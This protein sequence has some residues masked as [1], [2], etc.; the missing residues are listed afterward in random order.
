MTPI[1][2]LLL[3][4]L[5]AVALL[6]AAGGTAPAH[7]QGDTTAVALNTKDGS[8]LFKFAFQVRRTMRDVVDSTNAA[9]AVS[10]CSDCR[11]VAVSF[12]VLLVGGDASTQTPTNLALAI[13]QNCSSC[14]TAAFAY[15]FVLG[16]DGPA[17]FTAEGNRRLEELRKRLKDLETTTLSDTELNA[18]LD[19]AAAELRDIIQHELVPAG[20]PGDPG[21]GTQDATPAAGPDAASSPA[22]EPSP[23]GTPAATASPSPEATPT[24]SPTVT[25]S[26]TP[27]A[28]P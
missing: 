25:P 11:T 15:Q 1:R 20:N 18:I 14:D 19:Q 3:A 16:T 13:N 9:V 21:G 24:E 6:G 23:T 5:V 10:S 22:A 7:A 27:S 8:S 28:T 17:H 12:Q 4:S 2:R 26:T